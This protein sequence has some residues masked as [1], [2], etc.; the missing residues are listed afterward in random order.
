MFSCWVKFVGPLIPRRESPNF[1]IKTHLEGEDTSYTNRETAL[2]PAF[3]AGDSCVSAGL[4]SAEQDC[5]KFIERQW[6]ARK[7]GE[8]LA[9]L[10]FNS[11]E[12]EILARVAGLKILVDK[13]A[14]SE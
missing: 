4:L 8:E 6:I 2:T 5:W 9:I 13:S 10:T 12:C 7:S 14:S 1:G 3:P 11:A